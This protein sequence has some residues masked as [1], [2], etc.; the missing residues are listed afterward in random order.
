M[1]LTDWVVFFEAGGVGIM[2]KEDKLIGL[3]DQTG[4]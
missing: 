1:S 3:D 2:Q 4:K